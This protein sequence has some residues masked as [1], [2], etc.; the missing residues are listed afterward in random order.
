MASP[1]A[2]DTIHDYLV[3][4][5]SATPLAFENDGFN[6]PI[7][8]EPWVLVEIVGN[9]FEQES[10]GAETRDANLWREGGQ[11]YAHVMVPRG[12]GSRQAR[13]FAAQIVDLFRGEDIG[14]LTFRDA[15]IGAGEAGDVDGSYYRLTATIDWRRDL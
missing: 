15:S 14:M 2:Y 6:V 4:A 12:N 3:A 1:E 11:L 7:D 13:V 5:W 8:P 10:I 9:F